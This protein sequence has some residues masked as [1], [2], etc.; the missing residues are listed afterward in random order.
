MAVKIKGKGTSLLQEISSVYTAIPQL[1]SITIS[2]EKGETFASE[3][4]DGTAYKTKQWTGYNDPPTITAEGFYD[5]DDTTIQAFQTIVASGEPTNFKVT[6]TDTT[7]TSAIY[8]G[9]GFGFDKSVTMADG[10]GCSYT[11]ETSGAPS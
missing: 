9:V 3:T 10:V 8:P 1:K 7:P 2:G 11:I 4:L 6:Y 5:P